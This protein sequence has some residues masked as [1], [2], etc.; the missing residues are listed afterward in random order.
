MQYQK[1]H[2][3]HLKAVA[4]IEEATYEEAW[5]VK[6]FKEILPNEEARA[7]VV[8]EDKEVLGYMI[9]YNGSEGWI[10]ENLTVAKPHQR[11]G[12]GTELLGMVPKLVNDQKV[13][14]YAADKYLGMHL[15]LK[16]MGYVAISVEHDIDGEDY[17]QFVSEVAE[18]VDA[19]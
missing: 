12:I 11:R 16:K 1:M 7:I 2:T 5:T 6:Q 18:T 8:V 13:R 4:Q 15:L 14:V 9:L 3:R 10:I 17:Y 19:G